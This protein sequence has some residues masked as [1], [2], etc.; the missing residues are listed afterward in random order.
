MIY[1]RI[2]IVILAFF[3]RIEM[4]RALQEKAVGWSFIE[5]NRAKIWKE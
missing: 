2:T 1:V 5:E 4:E 3:R